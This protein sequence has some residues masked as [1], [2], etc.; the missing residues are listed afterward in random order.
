M[1]GLQ[2]ITGPTL[3]VLE[4]LLDAH[5]QQA[6]VHGW[7]IMKAIGRSG[8]TVYNVLDR[9]EDAGWL[10]GSWQEDAPP[11]RPRRRLYELTPTG[12]VGAASALAERRPRR[13]GWSVTNGV[14]R[15]RPAGGIA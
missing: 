9:L 10:T 12:T 7:V 5:H 8:P 11:G 4:V 3:D 6:L 14:V 13:R 1:A 15:P 2:R